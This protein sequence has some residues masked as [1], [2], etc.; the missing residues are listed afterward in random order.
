MI[1]RMRVSIR[2]SLSAL[3]LTL[4]A[5]A[6]SCGG[7]GPTAPVV[8]SRVV[9]SPA[10]ATVIA[11][12][13][14][15]FAAQAL[16]ASGAVMTGQAITWSSSDTSVAV[17]SAG[18]VTARR[19]GTANIIAASGTAQGIAPVTVIPVPVASVTVAPAP[20]TIFVSRTVQLVATPG[21]EAGVALTGRTVSWSS[22]DTTVATVAAT[23]LVTGRAV[24]TA[25]V[26]ATIEGKSG[27]AQIVV[28]LVPV[29]S[30]ALSPSAPSLVVG[31]ALTLT[32]VLKD[33]DGNVLTGRPVTWASSNT[34]AATVDGAG[35]VTAVAAGSTTITATS[36]SATA[37]ATVTVLAAPVA[38]VVVTAPGGT[39]SIPSASTLQLTAVAQ[40]SAGAT[41]ADRAITWSSSDTTAATVSSTGLVTMLK[42]GTV[43]ITATSE[44]KA[45]G[46]VLTGTPAAVASVSISP[47]STT[48]FADNTTTFT[49]VTKDALGRTL[50]GRA[51]AWSTN[52]PSAAPVTAAGLVTARL[53]GNALI[54]ATSEGKSAAAS[55]TIPYLSSIVAG[56]RHNCVL[57]ASGTIRCW[58]NNDSY[59]LNNPDTSARPA[60]VASALNFSVMSSKKNHL[61]AINSSDAAYCW[62]WNVSG[63][64]GNGTTALQQLIQPVSG[65]LGWLAV[66]ASDYSCGVAASGEGYCWGN[67]NGGVGDGTTGQQRVVPTKILGGRLLQ[68]ISVGATHACALD[69]SGQAFCWGAGE[70]G[71]LGTG[72]ISS[73]T[74]PVAVNTALRFAE[75]V[76]GVGYTCARTSSGTLYCWGGNSYGQLGDGSTTD[77]LVPTAVAGGLQFGTMTL[78]QTHACGISSGSTAYCWGSNSSG[79]LGTGDFSNRTAPTAV[80]GGRTFTALAA[81]GA[82]EGH[83]CGITVNS[84]VYCWGNNV[85]VQASG[86]GTSSS[87]P[88]LV[89]SPTS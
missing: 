33:A 50:T 17:V 10:S 21:D 69:R 77:R 8:A 18:M 86:L 39:T 26:T 83:T 27:S 34:A 44:G 4:L 41:L 24:G 47:S 37:Q 49:V 46:L 88:V 45:G 43:T 76:A 1:H 56:L 20:D 62:G 84:G 55:V 66:S 13:T 70:R 57:D 15:S 22:S 36:G 74:S 53:P 3:A 23:G 28:R 72:A 68:S 5:A 65:G 2:R 78:S 30:I 11:G 9:V 51:I 29:A 58:G 71:Q 75:I 14:A 31:S 87:T 64:L 63:E 54:V 42:T 81:G 67:A 61:C 79:Q 12:K 60:P 6:G 40:D 25:T 19:P 48:L 32:A 38:A 35:K 89:A 73:S 52:D 16:D 7:D 80:A 82:T 59:Q 85:P